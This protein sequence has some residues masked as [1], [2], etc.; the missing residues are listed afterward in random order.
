MLARHQ[1]ARSDGQQNIQAVLNLKVGDM[2]Y[3]YKADLNA[4]VSCTAMGA[5]S[6][7]TRKASR[8][9]AATKFDRA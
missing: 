2:D 6:V 8:A 7:Q 9:A 4:L 3:C 1:R 5:A